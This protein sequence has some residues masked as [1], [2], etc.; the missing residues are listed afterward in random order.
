MSIHIPDG[1]YFTKE[2]EWIRPDGARGKIGISDYAQQKLGDITFVELPGKGRSVKQFDLLSAIESVKA[3]SDIYSPVSGKILSVNSALENSPELINQS[4]Y[5]DGWIAEI[6]IAGTGEIG[7]LMDPSAYKKYTD[8][9][10]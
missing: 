8:G 10:E 3:A 5:D 7:N 6:E 2:H 9:L 4:P 1:F